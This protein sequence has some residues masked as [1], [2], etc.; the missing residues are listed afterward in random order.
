MR[1]GLVLTV[2]ALALVVLLAPPIGGGSG[3]AEQNLRACDGASGRQPRKI[4]APTF[5]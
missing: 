1:T 2:I 3:T 5:P 4:M